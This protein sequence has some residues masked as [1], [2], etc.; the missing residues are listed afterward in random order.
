MLAAQRAYEAGDL[1]SA[2]KLSRQALAISPLDIPAT[3]LHALVCARTG[4]RAAAIAYLQNACRRAPDAFEAHVALSTLLFGAGKT[5]EAIAHGQRTIDLHPE[6]VEVYRHFSRDLVTHSRHEEV[7]KVLERGVELFPDDLILNQDLAAV[8]SSLGRMRESAQQWEKTLALDPHLLAGWLKLGGLRLAATDAEGAIECGRQAVRVDENSADAQLLL[9][10]ALMDT[11]DAPEAEP[12][13]TRAIRINPAEHIGH[14]AL[15]VLFQQQGKFVEAEASL[16]KVISL[17]PNHGL[18]YDMMLRSRKVTAHDEPLLSRIESLLED[19]N[20]SDTDRSNMHYALGKA[21]E[22]LGQYEAAMAHYNLATELAAKVSFIDQIYDR[23]W[24]GTMIQRTMET[25]TPERLQSI[26]AKGSGTERPLLI[27]GMMRSGT[28]LVEQI[29][30]SHPLIDAGGELTYWHEQVGSVFDPALHKVHEEKLFEAADGYLKLLETISPSAARVTDKLPHNYVMLGL[31]HAVFPR[32]RIIHL[33][34][35]PIDNC[36]SV[37]TTPYQKPPAF[38]LVKAN[39]VFAYRQYLLLMEHWRRTLP[40]DC[41]LEVDYEELI[42]NREDVTRRMIDF[43]GLEWDDRCLRHESNKHR[44]STPSL[45]QVR[46]PI[47]K[48][49]VERWRKF[50]PW[51]GEFAELKDLL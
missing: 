49:S 24:Y 19:R 36:L 16:E 20:S 5:E 37:F 42:S 46:Q 31:V 30:S 9:A 10:L 6:D 1:P 14:A 43:A 50:E 18:S 39:I 26:A 15:A 22:D 38:A 44:V 4:K 40:P 51:L 21:R 3:V 11:N 29:L 41:F 23:E 35:N 7:L 28:T 45:W 13:L 25:F 27:V 48:T 17:N 34:R 2:E 12:H 8:L 47:Y 32:A 33:R